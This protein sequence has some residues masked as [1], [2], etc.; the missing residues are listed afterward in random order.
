MDFLGLKYQEE[1]LLYLL[2]LC[3]DAMIQHK[4]VG[5][6]GERINKAARGYGLKNPEL[7]G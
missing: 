7:L 1:M 2:D 4:S 5:S 6:E 3:N